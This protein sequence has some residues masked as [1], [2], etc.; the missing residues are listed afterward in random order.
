MTMWI[1]RVSIGVDLCGDLIDDESWYIAV[2]SEDSP[3][4]GWIDASTVDPRILER[5]M[6]EE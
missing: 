4:E 1:Q 3:G 2:E 6:T 5:I